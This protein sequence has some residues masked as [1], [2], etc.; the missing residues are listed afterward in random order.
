MR[1]SLKNI[2]NLRFTSREYAKKRGY[3][4]GGNIG[5]CHSPRTWLKRFIQLW[6]EFRENPVFTINDEGLLVFRGTDGYI[7]LNPYLLFPDLTSLPLSRKIQIT[8]N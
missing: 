3:Y 6:P 8:P 7:E 2:T 4:Y 5:R 1:V